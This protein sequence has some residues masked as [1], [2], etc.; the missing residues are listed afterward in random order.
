MTVLQAEARLAS[1]LK[2]RGLRL[3]KERTAIVRAAWALKQPFAA[4]EVAEALEA[5]GFH[6]SR[7][8][9]YQTLALLCA[10]GLLCRLMLGDD[11]AR[12]AFA[13]PGYLHLVCTGCGK[14]RREKDPTVVAH[15]KGRRFEAFTPAF[16]STVVYGTCSVCKR[17]S[18]KLATD[19]ARPAP[20]KK[21]KP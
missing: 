16:F 1:Y 20:A 4:A 15:F 11:E 9:C 18:R 10:M 3:T 7:S 12:Y 6:V 2:E 8:T 13:R 5:E 19:A 17:R 21:R 14:I